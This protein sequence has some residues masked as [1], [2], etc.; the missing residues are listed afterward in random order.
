MI[1]LCFPPRT[2][3]LWCAITFQWHLFQCVATC[4]LS[5]FQIIFTVLLESFLINIAIISSYELNVCFG[6]DF[7]RWG[8]CECLGAPMISP[9]SSMRCGFCTWTAEI[10]GGTIDHRQCW[11]HQWW[12]LFNLLFKYFHVIPGA[13]LCLLR[14]WC[15]VFLNCTHY[16]LHT[17]GCYHI[18]WQGQCNYIVSA[19]K[20]GMSTGTKKSRMWSMFFFV[21]VDSD[22]YHGPGVA[23]HP[24]SI[25][26]LYLS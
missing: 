26:M 5:I 3:Y 18:E 11:G 17:P 2:S 19:Q 10:D 9:L 23:E 4:R 14:C 1:C 12:G 20:Y 13:F 22:H 6:R 8:R 7:F 25:T 21:Q 15:L 16:F 24:S